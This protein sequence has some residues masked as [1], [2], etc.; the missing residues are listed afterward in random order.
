MIYLMEERSETMMGKLVSE[1]WQQNFCACS[2]L[3]S[4]WD[5]IDVSYVFLQLFESYSTLR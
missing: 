5:V 3:S 4:L 2:R 1:A